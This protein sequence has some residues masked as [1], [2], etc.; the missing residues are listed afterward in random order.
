MPRFYRI[1][2]RMNDRYPRSIRLKG[3]D[4]A[5]AGAYFVTICTHKR[6]CLLGEVVD[7][8]IMVSPYG[9]IAIACFREIPLHF[10]HAVVD[11]FVVMPNHLHGIIVITHGAHVEAQHAA[12]LHGSVNAPRVGAL[13]TI[14][15]SFKSA[16]AKCIN[17]LRG[18]PGTSFWQRNYYEHVIRNERDL[19]RIREYIAMNPLKWALD[20]ENPQRSGRSDEEDALFGFGHAP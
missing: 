15:R 20:R 6:D 9:E 5:Q 11:A 4:Y 8:E 2:T 18:M 7:E 16:S 17:E 3:Y 1:M 14:V 13:S 10:A 19:E 12:P